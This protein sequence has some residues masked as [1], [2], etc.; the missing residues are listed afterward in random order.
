MTMKPS[1]KIPALAGW[2][3]RAAYAAF[4]V[5]AFLFALQRTFPSEAVKERLILEAAAQGWQVRM[6]DIA[7]AGFAGVRVRE[8][9]LEG[10]NGAR[11]P[12]EEA[13]ARLRLW[14]LLLGR[15]SVAYDLSLFG[16]GLAGVAE[17]GRG[18]QRLVVKGQGIDLSRAAALK[19]ATGLD[20]AGTLR[21]DVDVTLDTREPAKSAGHVDVSVDKAAVNGG[22]VPLPGMTG[23]LTLP[24]MNL[25]AVVA[26]ATVKN[27]RAEFD[28]LEARSEDLEAVGE[29]LSVVLQPRLEYAPLYGRVRLKI[30]EG[31]W[32]KSGTTGLRSAAEMALAGARGKD[33]AYGFQVYGTL[34]HPQARPAAQ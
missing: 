34:G 19:K 13:R 22:E 10:R 23:G 9:T 6:D 32:Q 16:G 14:P 29:Q 31:F 1:F 20:L 21:A 28:K 30:S 2:K 4:F 17:E 3:L 27:G 12:I 25:G 33:G 15:R 7:P 8:A 26:R 5:L 11:L 24:R 18:W